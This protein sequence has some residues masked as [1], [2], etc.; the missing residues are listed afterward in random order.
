MTG[1]FFLMNLDPFSRSV[2]QHDLVG[3]AGNVPAQTYQIT[4]AAI[5][6]EPGLQ[7]GGVNGASRRLP[8]GAYTTF[9]TYGG[10][11]V[12]CLGVHLD[13]LQTSARLLGHN[14]SLDRKALRRALADVVSLGGFPES[15]LR[16]TLALPAGT[17]FATI[18]PFVPVA[19]SVYRT[20]V[21]TVTRTM[22][23][24]R[25]K[26]KSTAFIAP[27][28]HLKQALP[29]QVFEVL[30]CLPNGEIL[31]GLTSSFFAVQDGVL[32]TAGEGVLEGITRRIVLDI[33]PRILPVQL[34]PCRRADLG[35][36]AE[37]FIT[38][39]SRE[40]VPV[41]EIDGR[42]VGTGTPGP[43]TR[44]L[45]H[46]YRAFVRRVAQPLTHA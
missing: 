22:Q 9:R 30:M 19:E 20:G 13:R 6:P 45:L 41:V 18:T 32:H 40:V 4:G 16:V 10:N 3:P 14:V 2:S 43:V 5:T 44:R 29:P 35:A 42:P 24:D 23:R 8:P 46:R 1:C 34:V 36:V 38:S 26:A 11:R 33:A 31:E 15:R 27:S 25:P 28:R 12:L 7:E 17:T 39:S 37:A 21:H